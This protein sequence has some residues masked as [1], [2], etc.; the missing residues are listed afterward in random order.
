MFGRSCRGAH[1]RIEPFTDVSIQERLEVRVKWHVSSPWA[2]HVDGFGWFS[3]VV[4]PE[5]QE[6]KTI[7]KPPVVYDPSADEAKPLS[8]TW[9]SYWS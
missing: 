7:F 4:A 6:E 8:C 5:R 3:A 2:P 1:L 9:E